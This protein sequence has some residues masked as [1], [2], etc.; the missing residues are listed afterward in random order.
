MPVENLV[1]PFQN[2]LPG[3]HL[4]MGA[5]GVGKTRFIWSLLEDKDF[6]GEETIN[7][8]LTDSQ[9][10]TG[11]G[12]LPVPLV[13]IDPYSID[14]RWIAEPTQPGNFFTSLGYIPRATTFVECLAN[15]IRKVE[16]EVKHHI[17]VFVDFSTKYWQNNAF[18][19]QLAR[20][21]Y[22]SE[23]VVFEGKRPLSIWT[24][25]THLKELTPQAQGI[26]PYTHLILMN[27]VL[28][29]TLAELDSF[30]GKNLLPRANTFFV[31]GK[32]IGGF[33]YLPYT[34]SNIYYS[35]DN[36]LSK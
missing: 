36:N 7:I 17:R 21:H 22:I 4:V 15:Y 11:T 28:P 20:L 13:H 12:N 27:P 25:M 9:E 23:S 35:N 8:I 1:Q 18:V 34:D 2:F 32:T 3:N 14:M 29:S 24:V 16:G 5:A 26:L 6:S 10:H 19:E 31:Q 33:Y 30:F